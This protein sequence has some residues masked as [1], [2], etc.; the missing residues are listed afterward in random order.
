[1]IEDEVENW[2]DREE[3]LEFAVLEVAEAL[4]RKDS[5]VLCMRR[6]SKDNHSDED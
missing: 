5:A 4:A 1:M 2:R 6:G 3:N